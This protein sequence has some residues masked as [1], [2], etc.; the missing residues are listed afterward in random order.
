MNF[1][2]HVIIFDIDVCDIISFFNDKVCE[3][4]SWVYLDIIDETFSMMFDKC[5]I[6]SQCVQSHYIHTNE[7]GIG[8]NNLIPFN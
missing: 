4:W 6:G 3:K 8:V 5:L 7:Q 1:I 2:H